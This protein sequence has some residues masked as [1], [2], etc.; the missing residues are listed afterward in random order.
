MI[1]HKFAL[2]MRFNFLKESFDENDVSFILKE[3]TDV[4]TAS[5]VEGL[6]FYGGLAKINERDSSGIF[7]IVFTNGKMKF[8]RS[9]YK[10]L[11]DDAI[12]RSYADRRTPFLQNN[13][14]RSFEGLEYYGV[15]GSDGRLSE[16]S[17]RDIIFPSELKERKKF[18]E[19]RSIIIA[20]NSFKG[21]ISSVKAAERLTYAFRNE[22]PDVNIVPLPVADG[23]DG[24]LDVIES[25]VYSVR[26]GMN[27]SAPYGE[28][29]YAE[30]IVANGDTAIIESA[31]ASGLALCDG[32]ELDPL[33]AT[34]FGTGELILRAAHEGVRKIYVC[35]GGSATND[36][37]IGLARALGCKFLKSDGSEITN[38]SE[39]DQ[40]VS[41]DPSGIDK[42]VAAAKIY[43]V[44]DVRNPL[45]GE[46][47]A[48][49]TFGPQKGANEESLPLLEKGMLNMAR[50]LDNYANRQ[51][52][53]SP[54]AGAAGGMG[55]LLMALLGAEQ[56]D[57][58]EA[59]LSISGFDKKLSK[60]SL[61]VSGEGRVDATSIQGKALGAVI[62]HSKAKGV[63]VAI[64]TGSLG[65]GHE[66]VTQHAVFCELTRS[67]ENAIEHFDEAAKRLAVKAKELI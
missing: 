33:T 7:T 45:T 44:C 23:G 4:L 37:G 14:I 29:K 57:G 16:G 35:L 62:E 32:I 21:T 65:E 66:A 34:S 58:A 53:L 46:N 50:I 17:G 18:S 22:M 61:V 2:G 54:G 67:C 51:I 19:E 59:V 5:D 56:I 63:P 48:T 24:T 26:H 10:K 6:H 52:S 9:V 28:K 38:A 41:V 20:P 3:V 60:A 47:G 64:I 12:L 15:I 27:V 43:A 8:M 13:V 42:A 1:I 55:A 30:Y 36:C 31:R 39:M 40:A 25:S 49:C 11:N